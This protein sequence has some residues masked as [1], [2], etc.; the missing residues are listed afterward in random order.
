M[1]LELAEFKGATP[2]E[3]IGGT[4]VP[5]GRRLPYLL[6]MP[7]YG[8]YWFQLQKTDAEERFGPTPAPELFTLVL[9]GGAETLLE[10]RERQAFERTVAPRFLESRRWF[11]GKDSGVADVH[12]AGVALP[13]QMAGKA[14]I[15]VRLSVTLRNGETQ[16]YFTPLVIEEN[17]D[18]EQIPPYAVARVRRGSR[19]GLVLDADADP[20]FGAALVQGMVEGREM[21]LGEGARLKFSGS[22]ALHAEPPVTQ[23]DV[24]RLGGEQSNTSIAV[25]ERMMLKI[26][27]RLSP[28]VNPEV[29]IGR[30]LTD[31]A[32]FKNTP[33]LLGAMERIDREGMPT[34]LGILQRYRAQ[35]GRR[36]GLDHRG[37]EARAGNAVAARRRDRARSARRLRRLPALRGHARPAHGR[38]ARR[39]RD[40][41]GRSRFRDRS[42]DR[43]RSAQARSKRARAEAR[44]CWR[45]SNA[46]RKAIRRIAALLGRATSCCVS[47]T[48]SRS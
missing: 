18:D 42:A 47:T 5:A 35:P 26:Y 6:T 40:A 27:R 29:E 1:E 11:A 3:L 15:L 22:E 13:R 38:V 39:A 9:T 45:N 7:A 4:R 33:A 46:G 41:D 30:F 21:P 23:A 19:M 36:V 31:V 28:G 25:G 48:P 8:F 43:G 10:N 2:V 32:G 17:R 37:V 16:M 24:R 14:F 12:I 44:R 20:A 34:A